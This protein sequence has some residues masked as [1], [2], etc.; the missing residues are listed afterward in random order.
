MKAVLSRTP[1]PPETLEVADIEA[2]A[3]GDGEVAIRVAACG[4]NFPDALIIEDRYQFR[5]PRPFAPG[6]EVS[7]TVAAVG[8][9]V[10][11]LR[12]GMRVLASLGW[13]GMAEQAV[14]R[15]ERCV[16]IPDTMPFDEAAAFL[17]TYGTSWHALVDRGHLRSG[18]TLL[19][20]GAA[21]GVG[22]A[23]VEIGKALGARVVAAC[24]STDKVALAKACG[25]DAGVVYP[26]GPFDKEGAR[27]LADLFKSACG[28]GGADVVYDAVGGDYSEAALRAIA[29]EGRF[30]VVGFPAG[31]AKIPLNLALLKGCE[32][33]GVFWGEFVRRDP[34]RHASNVKDLFD[35]Y[36][37]GQIRP[38][39]SKRFALAQGHEAIAWLASRQALGKVVVVVD[40][41][42]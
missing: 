9:G 25:A 19:V 26:R 16:V 36:E 6:G 30:L 18:H 20:L 22:T 1:G 8:P 28:A 14:T 3:P 29:W 17:M 13:G 41:A 21:G 40:E 4:V 38:R 2:P 12:P 24:S 31:I 15:A 39:V 34:V 37:N 42:G 27:A 32:I 35:L 7:G 33:A 11:G 5:P 10:T 23:A